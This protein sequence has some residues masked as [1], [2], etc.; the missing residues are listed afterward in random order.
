MKKIKLEIPLDE[1]LEVVAVMEGT[2]ESLG[3]ICEDDA[4]LGRGIATI[5]NIRDRVKKAIINQATHKEIE[6]CM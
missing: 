5:I 1:A 2:K 3:R 4:E 6:S